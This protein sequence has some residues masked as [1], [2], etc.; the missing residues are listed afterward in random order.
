[1]SLVKSIKILGDSILKGVQLNKENNRYCIDNNIDINAISDKYSLEIENLSR[2]GYTITAGERLLNQRMEKGMTC[3]AVVMDYGG[4]D[5]DFKWKEISDD[6][7]ALHMPNTEIGVFEATYRRIIAF[8]KGKGITPIL[9]TLPPIDPQKYFN[10]FC[11]DKLNK[12]NILS[13]L[14]GVNTIYRYQEN[15]SRC[16]EKIATDTDTDFV[17]LRGAFLANRRIDD[18]LCEDGIHPN[19]N[20]QKVIERAFMDFADRKLVKA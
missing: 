11:S 7:S 4:N 1:M 9:T 15:Y 20:G 6:P 10:W 13:W 12:E 17:D 16:I 14:G 3:D 5:C 19:T 18:L 2:F 8:L